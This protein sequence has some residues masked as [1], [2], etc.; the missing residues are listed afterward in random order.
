MRRGTIIAGLICLNL[1]LLAGLAYVWKNRAPAA[2]AST[3]AATV[4]GEGSTKTIT[5]KIHVPT[6]QPEVPSR[7]TWRFIESTDFKQYITNL[8]AVGCPEQTIQDIVIAEV[9]KLYAS[10]EA[11]LRLRPEHLKPWETFG[12]STRVAMDRERR[13]RQLLR[14]KRA[15]LKELLGIDVPVEIPQSFAGISRRDQSRYEEALAKLPEGKRDLVRAIQEQYWD[16]TEEL[17]ARTMGFWEPQDNEERRRLR[18][19]LRGSLAKTLT[20]DELLDYDI[21]TSSNAS[22][23]RAEMAAVNVT[24]Q[25]FRELFKSRHAVDEEFNTN[26]N[27]NDPDAS[28]KRADARRL[29]ED[30][31]KSVLGEQRYADYQRSRD[32]QFRNLARLAQETGLPSETA[33]KA[34]DVQRLARDE[35]SRLRSN[36]DFTPEQRDQSM[37]QIQTELDA[38]MTQLL[39]KEAFDR[40]QQNYGGARI[41]Y[42]R[43]TAT[44]RVPPR[45]VAPGTV[46]LAP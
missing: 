24:D 4:T 17:E 30:N 5:R 12:V 2:A 42:E 34:W 28:R 33:I 36:P 22:R 14:E 18:A 21:G 27:P 41:F 38:T 43:G 44:F 37:R 7:F 23:Y 35:S 9:N 32:S 26:P 8:R 25:E 1:G 15:L 6:G 29:L 31:M 39:G 20:S 10:R 16:K 46:I 19:E 13:L 40:F 11:A 45:P 3:R